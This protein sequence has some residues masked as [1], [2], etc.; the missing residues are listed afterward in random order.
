MFTLRLRN[1]DCILECVVQNAVT[2]TRLGSRSDDNRWRESI[3]GNIN[4]YAVVV[5]DTMPDLDD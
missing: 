3:D 2:R 5:V 4:V 1:A